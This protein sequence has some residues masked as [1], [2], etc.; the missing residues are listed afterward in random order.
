[1]SAQ[2][3]LVLAVS[4]TQSIADRIK[5]FDWQGISRSLDERGSA[6]VERLL[7]PDECRSLTALYPEEEPFRSR[8]V[9]ERH[10]FGRGEYKY[11]AYPL[12]NIMSRLRSAFYS[13]FQASLSA[14]THRL[15]Y[16]TWRRA[17]RASVVRLP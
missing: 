13:R 3:N 12:P 5:A 10:G 2:A 8:V 15:S 14:R 9:M 1:M 4:A 6:I 7:S 16:P 17:S 11:F